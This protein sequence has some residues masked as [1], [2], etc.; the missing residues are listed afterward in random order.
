MRVRIGA[1]EAQKRGAARYDPG[2]PFYFASTVP[3]SLFL[4]LLFGSWVLSN[5]VFAAIYLAEPGSIANARRGALSDAFFFSVETMA[6]VGYGVF[7][8][9]TLYGH[10]VSTIEIFYGMAF[11]AIAT[12]LTFLRFSRPKPRFVYA[13][14]PVVDAFNGH[15]A[16]MVR[17]ANGRTSTLTDATAKLSVL[18][19]E[20]TR[21]GRTFRRFYSLPLARHHL[22]RTARC[23]EWT[24]TGSASGTQ[25]CT[26][27]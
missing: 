3:W 2:D 24:R 6:T 8:P 10:I 26:S 19:D 21:E 22:P 15:P 16:L 14:N 9:A 18:L 1:Y 5:L 27:R 20:V 4:L 17:V 13:R 11:A 7:T 25:G 23:M 12:G